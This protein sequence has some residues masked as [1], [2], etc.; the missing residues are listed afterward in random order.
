M[1]LQ[2]SCQ[3]LRIR[4]S[5][6]DIDVLGKQF[7]LTEHISI[8]QSD[9]AFQ[10]DLRQKVRESIIE[11][12]DYQILIQVPKDK[13]LAWIKSPDIEFEFRQKSKDRED[14]KVSIEKDL[15]SIK[16]VE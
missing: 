14:L 1:K 13:F 15:K 5:P 7:F 6:I 16:R 2:L 4:L 11:F 3:N 12:F 8:I 10:L 9:F